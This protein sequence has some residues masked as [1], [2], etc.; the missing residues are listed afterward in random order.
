MANTSTAKYPNN[1]PG[2]ASKPANQGSAGNSKAVT[3]QPRYDGMPKASK[4]G[5]SVTMFTA[6]PSGTHGSK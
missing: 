6:Q 2:K 3:Q 4:P 1:Q 5:A